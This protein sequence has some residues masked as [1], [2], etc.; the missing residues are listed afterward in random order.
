MENTIQ[1]E[2]PQVEN[3]EK[4]GGGRRSQNKNV[5]VETKKIVPKDI[6]RTQG[7]EKRKEL[8]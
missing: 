7:T 6:D 2:T 8:K 4:R 3:T 5:K 1:N